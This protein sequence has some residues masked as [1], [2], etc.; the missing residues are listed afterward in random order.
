MLT[1]ARRLSA[2]H[3]RP[4]PMPHG[5]VHISAQAS[6]PG[7]ARAL[8][9]L[10]R[11][12]SKKPGFV[13]SLCVRTRPGAAALIL[14]AAAPNPF[15]PRDER[16]RR[17]PGRDRSQRHRRVGGQHAASTAERS[18][19]LGLSA[20][21]RL[22]GSKL[23]DRRRVE[24]WVSHGTRGGFAAAGAASR[25][26]SA[27]AKLARPARQTPAR[28]AELFDLGRVPGSQANS[29]GVAGRRH[30]HDPP[31]RSR[32]LSRVRRRR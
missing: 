26:F 20:L 6:R 10:M 24:R 1:H 29:L 27:T 22:A 9:F 2:D 19:S 25:S 7:F 5:W 31:C 16:S 15:K 30:H 12:R 21:N 14:R 8:P 3:R 28:S 4:Q 32:H 13:C 11:A 23:L 18:M 17:R